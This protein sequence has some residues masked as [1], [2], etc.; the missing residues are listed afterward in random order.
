[1]CYLYV[2][3]LYSIYFL[4]SSQAQTGYLI[5]RNNFLRAGIANPLV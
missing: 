2:I 1:M 3:Y 4:A 5:W